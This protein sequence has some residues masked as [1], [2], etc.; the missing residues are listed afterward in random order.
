MLLR[1]RRQ[2]REGLP[3]GWRD[4]LEQRSGQWRLLRPDERERLGELADWLLREKRWEAA[5]EF[6]L[7]DEART[8]IS[9]HAAL[10]VLGL[11][12]TWYDGIGA[13]V[14]RSGS[15][16]QYGRS[17][18]PVKGTVTGGDDQWID[19]EAHHGDGP[20][21]VS[22][23]AA[24]REAQQL[25]LGRDVVLHEFAH[26]IDMYD[27]VLDGTPLLAT[28]AETQ[29]WVDVCTRHYD[30]VRFGVAKDGSSPFLRSYA[31][32]NVAEF[33]AVATETFF[34]RPIE[35]AERKPELYEV[36]AAFYR[37]DPAQRLREFVAANAQ[38]ALARMALNPPRIVVRS[39]PRPV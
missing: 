33:F 24:R 31:G 3:D 29:R 39:R 34:T 25:R 11:D 32:T 30:D 23:R 21:M 13:I 15:M 8:V 35:L 14:V 22:W 19:G 38:A 26:K 18:G 1:H 4:I 28:D 7:T 37:Q 17:S 20:L 10:L 6:E 12:E 9:A 2:P 36:F 16:T 5:R 27:G